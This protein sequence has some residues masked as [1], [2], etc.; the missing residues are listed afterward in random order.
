MS[1]EASH[2]TDLPTESSFVTKMTVHI[3][4]HREVYLLRKARVQP[5]K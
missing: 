4:P 3:P 1:F 2:R 5:V